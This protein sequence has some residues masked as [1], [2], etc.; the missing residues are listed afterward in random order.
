M[1]AEHHHNLYMAMAR[2][3][4]KA[5][6]NAARPRQPKCAAMQGPTARKAASK[7]RNTRPLRGTR[8]SDAA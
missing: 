2:G 4:F 6:K 8:P 3:V 1:E 5:A 7:M